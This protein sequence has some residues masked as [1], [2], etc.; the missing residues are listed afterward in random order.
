MPPV[1]GLDIGR[2]SFTAVEISR[3]NKNKIATLE[4]AY[5]CNNCVSS[6][7]SRMADELKHF[8]SESGFGTKKAVLAIPEAKVFSTIINVPFR[9]EKE[10]SSFLEVQGNKIFP[11]PLSE[12]VYSFAILG[13]NEINKAEVDVNVVASGKDYV[14]NLFDIT[15]NAGLE[16]LAIESE[17]Y[18]TVRALI[19]GQNI[20]ENQAILVVNVG[21]GDADMMVIRNGFVRFSRNVTLGGVT[22][23]RAISQALGV[24]E[25]QAEEYKKSYGLDD[26]VLEG[27][28]INAMKPVAETLINE[29]KRTINFYSTRNS[30]SEFVRVIYSGSAVMPGLLAFSA[31][32]LGM[33]VELANPF[34]GL[35]F[36]SKTNKVKENLINSG[37]IYTISVGL[38]LKE[39]V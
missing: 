20:S 31:E 3:N 1:I 8:I 21:V 7:S 11:R 39:V 14:A 24:S 17:A 16:V 10:V 23:T 22:F 9:T 4:N 37:P 36:S 15:R 34:A 5:I 35:N 29:I 32:N 28:I 27:K 30:F 12:L 25:E 26:T 38:A 33:E 6:D 2:S 13:P 19:R 18:A